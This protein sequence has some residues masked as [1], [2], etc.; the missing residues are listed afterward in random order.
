MGSLCALVQ[1]A[2]QH[3]AGAVAEPTA[4]T[5]ISETS[6]NDRPIISAPLNAFLLMIYTIHGCPLRILFAGSIFLALQRRWLTYD[7]LGRA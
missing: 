2:I 5:T 1:V 7:P 6:R 4:A 3:A